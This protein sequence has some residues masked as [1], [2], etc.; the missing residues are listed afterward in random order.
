MVKQQSIFQ[1]L[2]ESMKRNKTPLENN[3]ELYSFLKSRLFRAK[4]DNG[5]N[6]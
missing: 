3:E 6:P 1:K 4:E 5:N 2:I